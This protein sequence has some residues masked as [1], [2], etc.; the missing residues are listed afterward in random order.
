M[1]EEPPNFS[2]NHKNDYPWHLVDGGNNESIRVCRGCS[3]KYSRSA[4][5]PAPA[6][7]PASGNFSRPKQNTRDRRRQAD[8]HEYRTAR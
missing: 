2:S 8:M 5:A 6:L 1:A 7:A 4:P 3:D